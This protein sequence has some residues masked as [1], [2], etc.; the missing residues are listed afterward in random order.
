MFISYIM[1]FL[2]HLVPIYYIKTSDG[3]CL[4][5]S[6]SWGSGKFAT[7]SMTFQGCDGNNDGQKWLL[8][9]KTS[10][11]FQILNLQYK[12]QLDC[13]SSTSVY[14]NNYSYDNNN[15][16]WSSIDGTSLKNKA[17]SYLVNNNGSPGLSTSSYSWNWV[18]A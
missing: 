17:Y 7:Y 14:C 18:L 10:T 5:L 8:I 12:C 3:K 16:K 2:F 15:Q 9:S 11:Y 4:T 13:S 6:N 1:I